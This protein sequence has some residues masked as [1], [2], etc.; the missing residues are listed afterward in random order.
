[1]SSQIQI[2]G[3]TK[4]KSLTGV[5]VG[6]TGVVS[7]LNI[8]G[9]LGIPQLDV[10]G[11][12]LV[13]Q[14][15]NSVMEYKGTWDA[16]TNTP[17]LANG[18]GNQGDVYLCSVAGTV[19]FGAGAIS[20]VVSDQ[21]IYSGSIWQKASGTN[22]TVTSVGLSTNAGAITIGS[23][24]IT[25][26]GTIT[27]NFNGTNLQY[28]NGAGNL[29]TFPT[30]ITSIGLTMPS[31]F[32]VA[33]S[34]LT[35]NGTIAVTGAGYASQYIRGDGT[36]ADFPS[37]G[38]GGSSV[39]YYLNGGT[40][41]GT[42][43][44][45]TYYE[46]SKIA[47]IGTGVDFAKSGDGF[48]VAFLTDANDPAQ[49][50]IPAGNWNYE[51]YA[52]MSA[53]GGTPQLY[54]ELYKYDGTTF[55][56]IA[57]SANEILYDGT[58]LNLY[59]FA[60]A[61]PAT[62][63][64]LTD[65]L[66]IKLYAT[67]SGGKTTT[68]HTQ[69]GHLCQVITTFSTGIT[70]L[71]GLTAQV[72]YFQTG[73]SGTDFN[74]SSTTATHTFNIPDA[75][76]TA[77]GLITTGTQT[78]AGAK[79]FSG[80]VTFTSSLTT[81]SNVTFSNS[82]FTLVLQ[83]PTL[84]VNRTVTLP[85][86]T[87]TL[88]LTS[89]LSGYV[90]LATTQTISGAKTFSAATAFS[91]TTSHIGTAGFGAGS[92]TAI[93][94]ADGTLI[95][96]KIRLYADFSP[97]TKYHN[98]VSAA[99]QNRD[100]VIPNASGTLALTS[101][102]TSGTVTSVAALTIGTTG[103]DLSSTVATSTTT[104][105]IT[106]NVPTASAS[107]RGALSSAD[108][109][110]F[111]NKQSALTNPVLASGSW[112]SGYLP[113]ING[114][115]TIGNS[116]IFDNGTL[117][118]IGNAVPTFTLDLQGE[119]RARPITSYGTGQTGKGMSLRYDTV[120]ANDFGYLV[121]YNWSTAAYQ[122]FRIDSLRTIFNTGN[123]LIN[124]I[125]D[126]NLYKLD[127]NGTARVTGA[128]TFDSTTR[129]NGGTSTIYSSSE[130]RLNLNTVPD[131]EQTTGWLY[132]NYDVTLGS[133]GIVNIQ[134]LTTTVLSVLDFRNLANNTATG[135]GGNVRIA[136][137]VAQG[138]DIGAGLSLG[139]WTTSTG[140][141]S[142][143]GRIVGRKENGTSGN[144]AGYL[145]FETANASPNQTSEKMRI[146]S[147]GSVGIGC[148]PAYT[149]DVNGTGRFSGALSADRVLTVNNTNNSTLVAGGIE[150]QSYS[151]NNCW[152]GN[153]I[154]FDGV[155]FKARN[156]GYVPQIYF[157]S[158]GS[159][160]L[161]T[162]S[163]TVTAGGNSNNLVRLTI[164][165]TGAATFSSSVTAANSITVTASDNT[166]APQ[167]VMSQ[168]G[169]N[170]YSAI[171]INRADGTGIAAGLGSALVLRSGDASDSPIQFATANNVRMTIASTGNVG[172]GINTASTKLQV[173][174]SGN[175]VTI[176]SDNNTL[177]LGLGYQG[178][179]HGYL[180]GFS[181]RLEAYSNNG[182][183]VYLSSSSTWIAASDIKR[184]RNFETYSLGL[185][186]ILGLKPKL[187]NMDFQKDGDDKQLGLVAQ[188]VKEFI[189][190]AF[191]QSEKFI[192]LNYNYIIVTMVNAIKELKAEID[193]LKNK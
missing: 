66:A 67:N 48:I 179:I 28:V 95:I 152:I 180:G 136:T 129:V 41:Q 145:S 44:G 23:S 18:T 16:S 161:K 4:V 125:A 6:T 131:G 135:N 58:N 164:E 103:T 62:T 84:S 117:I 146:T 184:K 89:D 150:I 132:S 86:G 137:S 138:I 45:T 94:G 50:N 169:G 5:L 105:V 113:K 56:L 127:V 153:N 167:F 69:N 81:T 98:I 70:A 72:Q 108:W 1:M 101:Q 112:T 7:S 32:S 160:A 121:S 46:M 191:E 34:P 75:S 148:T 40:S 42:I 71:N 162:G 27:A 55:T 163:T 96:P 156:A 39:S 171:G 37:S 189:P 85:D 77:R 14:L 9:S 143:F 142:T 97:A 104:P 88:A 187:Y 74:I 2:T 65:R 93:D 3:E 63:L 176:Y 83:P 140:G 22:G 186:A 49:L 73:T 10:N 120:G 61:V 59:T 154:Y 166:I 107:N 31:A 60:M 92:P 12:I 114:T 157:Q 47:V 170:T 118:G 147:T 8:D 100:I 24:P 87:G 172:I 90:T 110:T 25:T 193:T 91:S 151:V 21:V 80:G 130:A 33:N 82:G 13:S 181:S 109:T 35:A 115:Y 122:E 68:V 123:V 177:S 190:L 124:T 126:T 99:T 175:V 188:E 19:N 106:L 26:S 29:T 102:L 134:A 155:G 57:T 144:T 79:T 38:G 51:I 53:N 119:F 30:L 64:A 52:Q 141:A 158:D 185:N 11:K 133:V 168:T 183:Y 76:A 173:M 192:G 54:A 178:T 149:L 15:P 111:N 36:L 128:A 20:F 17:T 116:Q 174:G 43:G 139:G 78:I 182:G 159:I 165:N